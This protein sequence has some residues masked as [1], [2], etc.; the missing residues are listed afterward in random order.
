MRILIVTAYTWNMEPC[1]PSLLLLLLPVVLVFSPSPVLLLPLLPLL[2]LLL[3]LLPHPSCTILAP[4]H[5]PASFVP[6][7]LPAISPPMCVL[8]VL[9]LLFS[10]LLLQRTQPLLLLLLLAF[11]LLLQ[12]RLPTIA[13]GSVPCQHALPA[14]GKRPHTNLCATPAP[15]RR[16]SKNHTNR[17]TPSN[18]GSRSSRNSRSKVNSQISRSQNIMSGKRHGLQKKAL[19]QH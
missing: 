15:H 7:D 16:R 18:R 4:V 5:L 17:S 10:P 6:L 12:H 8:P 13:V 19:E 2:L 9:L 11:V 1:A 14:N 3:L